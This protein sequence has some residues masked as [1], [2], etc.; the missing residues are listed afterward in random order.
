MMGIW[1]IIILLVFCGV[2][3]G[4]VVAVVLFVNS[5]KPARGEDEWERDEPGGGPPDLPS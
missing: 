5:R 2:I 1:E 3:A 4:V